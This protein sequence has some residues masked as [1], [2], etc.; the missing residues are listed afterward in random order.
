M[1]NLILI[2]LICCLF[3]CSNESPPM[4]KKNHTTQQ[5]I[6]LDSKNFERE[7]EGKRVHLYTLKNKNGLVAQITNYGGRVVSLWTPDKA[8]NLED[9]VLGYET[10]EGYQKPN[11]AY[12]GALVGRYANRIGKATFQLN[13]KT[14]TLAANN[15]E[16][17]LH[18][19]IKGFSHVVWAARPINPQQLEL[20]YLSPDGEEGYP[21]NLNVKVVYSLTDAN[22]LKVEYT[23]TTDQATPVNL[24]HHSYFNLNGAGNGNIHNH[25]LRLNANRY[26]PV[27]KGLIPNGELASVA[28][29]PMDFRQARAIGQRIDEDFEQLK[30]GGGYDHNW[31][32]N[33][34]GNKLMLAA[35]VYAP[36]SGRSMEVY[37]NEPG[38]Q[39]YA[40]NFLDGS[41]MGKN[42]KNYPRRSA[43]CLETQHFPDSPNKENFPT[44]ILQINEV[45][46]SICSYKFGI[47]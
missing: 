23:A 26:T 24:T 6:L 34:K 19:G 14:Y 7:I 25:I 35:E 20:T 39:F 10:L 33:S 22:E 13:E 8:G 3:S 5:P 12:F 9:I 30:H 40:G 32:L 45:Y 47:K 29:T 43:F 17:H 38:I 4:E 31:V 15:G 46:Y 11:E 2:Y 16:N 44:T 28:N 27:D 36:K 1:K 37:T 18:G 21:G 42:G 41:D